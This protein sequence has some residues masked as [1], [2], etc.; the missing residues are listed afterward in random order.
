MSYARGAWLILLLAVWRWPI[1]DHYYQQASAQTVITQRCVRVCVCV[2][3]RARAVSSLCPVS[4]SSP[5]TLRLPVHNTGHPVSTDPYRSGVSIEQW[6]R[7]PTFI[8]HLSDKRTNR[9]TDKQTCP[10]VCLSV[11]SKVGSR[12]LRKGAVPPLPFNLSFRSPFPSLF[13]TVSIL[14]PLSSPPLK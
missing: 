12:N 7:V 1:L 2:C 6:S 5:A 13:S 14:L 4:F 9:Q 10:Y 11:V 3:A 8:L